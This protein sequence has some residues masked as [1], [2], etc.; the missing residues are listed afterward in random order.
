MDFQDTKRDEE[1]NP[2]ITI[3]GDGTREEIAKI[4][5]NKEGCGYELV[6]QP[7]I[8]SRDDG[9]YNFTIYVKRKEG[10]TLL[11]VIIFTCIML[12]FA[13]LYY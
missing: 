11:L 9:R 2:V 1:E 7:A 12:L 3:S 8:S 13:S 5:K 6:M 10:G 4:I